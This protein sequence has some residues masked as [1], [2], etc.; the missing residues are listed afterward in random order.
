[1]AIGKPCCH[2]FCMFVEVEDLF[3]AQGN[4]VCW[5]VC[6]VVGLRIIIDGG[7]FTSYMSKKIGRRYNFSRVCAL[8]ISNKE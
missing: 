3:L 7:A 2:F 4:W 5:S 1:M 6:I 8:Y